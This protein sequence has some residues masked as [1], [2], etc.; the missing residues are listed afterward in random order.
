MLKKILFSIALLA[1]V[2]VSFTGYVYLKLTHQVEG[3]YFESNGTSIHYTIQGKGEPVILVHGF[4][5]NAD[6]NWRLPG[7]VDLLGEHYQVITLDN[8]G[9]GLSDKPHDNTAY[10]MNMVDDIINLMNHLDIEQAHLVGYS[11]GGIISLKAATTYPEKWTT[12]SCM[13]MGWEDPDDLEFLTE[14]QSITNDLKAGKAIDPPGSVIDSSIKPSTLHRFWANIM[15]GY[16][17]D[18]LALA[19]TLEGATALA[20][21]EEDLAKLTMPTLCVIGTED[22]FYKSAQALSIKVKHLEKVEIVG[23]DHVRAMQAPELSAAL[24]EF[25]DKHSQPSDNI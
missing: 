10:G 13:G 19:A 1:L 23:A 22:M 2:I 14:L 18:P 21:P 15:T 17:N 20:V 3:Q 16:L 12:V 24:V 25:L 5:A 6:L 9:A 8:R 11:L 4:A 7:I